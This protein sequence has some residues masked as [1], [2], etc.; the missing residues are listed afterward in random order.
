M[1]YRSVLK[2]Y[3][4][5]QCRN[6]CFI[7]NVH[8]RYRIV[9]EINR[10]YCDIKTNE[11]LLFSKSAET[12]IP[13]VL[14]IKRTIKNS[15]SFEIQDG[16]SCIQSKCPVCDVNRKGVTNDIYINKTSGNYLS[17]RL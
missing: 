10:S 7:K 17:F 15:G 16:F 1:L 13:S 11:E 5:V 6:S 9:F 4:N 8:N 14:K 12:T 3:P 2:L